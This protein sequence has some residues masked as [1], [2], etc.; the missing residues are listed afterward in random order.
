MTLN[1]GVARA[2]RSFI[3]ECGGI[4]RR[5]PGGRKCGVVP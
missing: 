1:D 3:Q 4:S 2:A 5:V